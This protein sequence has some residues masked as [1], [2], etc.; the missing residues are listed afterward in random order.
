LAFHCFLK[1]CPHAVQN[2]FFSHADKLGLGLLS[3]LPALGLLSSL[4]ALNGTRSKSRARNPYQELRH[5]P[6]VRVA[7]IAAPSLFD[8]RKLGF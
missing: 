2:S 1:G 8:S 5:H 4:P 3:S 7:R 6:C